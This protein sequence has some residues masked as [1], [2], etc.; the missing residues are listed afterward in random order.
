MSLLPP[1]L[2]PLS[3]RPQSPFPSSTSAAA[4][5]APAVR[6][7]RKRLSGV[8]IGLIGLAACAML[9][10]MLVLGALG[11]LIV[12]CW[13]L[14]ADQA[15]TALQDDAVVQERIGQIHTMRVDLYRTG[16]AP[17]GDDFVFNVEGDRGAGRVHATWVSAGAESETLTNGTLNMR[18]GSE[19]ALPGAT[20]E[21]TE[22]DSADSWE[23]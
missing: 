14:F 3:P 4:P 8:A 21:N 18:D 13:S 10:G 12:T 20:A 17:G 19:Y 5:S 23:Q 11:W 2:P 1:P 9:F 15:R 16:L 7:V 22:T 6:P